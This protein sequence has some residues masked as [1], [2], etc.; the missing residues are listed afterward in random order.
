M[1]ESIQQ[2]F[3]NDHHLCDSLFA[4]TEASAAQSR[5]DMAI[6]KFE[7][8]QQRLAKHIA[9]EE[10]VLFPALEAHDGARG[11]PTQV[12]RSEHDQMRRLLGQLRSAVEGRDGTTVLGLSD[13]LWLLMQQHNLKEETV[14]YP[15]LDRLLCNGDLT[16]AEALGLPTHAV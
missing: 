1:M 3:T 7:C 16:L 5:W 6:A 14:L 13:T 11:G 8:F 2:S 12:M 10:G 4:E 15:M 9:Q